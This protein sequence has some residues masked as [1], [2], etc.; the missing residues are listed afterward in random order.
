LKALV[1]TGPGVVQ[2]DE[3]PEP[4][5]GLDETVVSVARAGICGSE[6][7]GIRQPSF[8]K[9]PLIMGHEFAGRTP[10][11]RRVAVNPLLVCGS[12]EP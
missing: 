7:H 5:A 4:R 10:D 8:R 2:V 12:L 9:P 1:F 3:V 6:L 11:G